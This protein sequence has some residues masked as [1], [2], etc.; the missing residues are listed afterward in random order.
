MEADP[1]TP[2]ARQEEL[3]ELAY[4]YVLDNGL[5]DMSLRPLA[6]A[7]G[8]SP[9]VLLFLFG[10]KDGLVRALLARARLDELALLEAIRARAVDEGL[11]T[12]VRAIWGWLTDRRHRRL[13]AL[14]VQAYARSLTETT[15]PWANFAQSTVTDWL[16]ILTAA[17]PPHQRD[18]EAGLAQRTLA[19]AVLRGA[20]LDL[21]ATND[22]A[23][24][25]AAFDRALAAGL[26][27]TRS[28]RR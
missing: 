15:G 9:R 19:L 12:T 11:E 25:A 24:V 22:V 3:L 6:A 10:S 27:R 17:Q 4:Q 5:D 23:R 16:G 14:W 18:S 1:R 28:P 21:L 7:I 2:S 26:W 20:V 13:L 8:S